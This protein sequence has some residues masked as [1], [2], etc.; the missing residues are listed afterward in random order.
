MIR[1]LFLW[2]PT[3]RDITWFYENHSGDD[4]DYTWQVLSYFTFEYNIQ[5]PKTKKRQ[6]F[7]V[8]SQAL[9]SFYMQ[10]PARYLEHSW[11]TI[12]I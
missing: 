4:T 7:R 10:Y 12:S 1:A 6:L 2:I 11:Q 3:T 8:K 9:F 5:H